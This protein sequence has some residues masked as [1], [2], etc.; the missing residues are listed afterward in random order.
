[1][2]RLLEVVVIARRYGVVA[3]IDILMP[4]LRSK[5]RSF[6]PHYQVQAFIGCAL[7]K[8]QLSVGLPIKPVLPQQDKRQRGYRA[9][10]CRVGSDSHLVIEP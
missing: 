9:M 2:A 6:A 10:G 4:Q 3:K 5:F 8:I 7:P 1:M